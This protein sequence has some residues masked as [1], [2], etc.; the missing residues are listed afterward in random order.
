MVA[1]S[2]GRLHFLIFCYVTVPKP[3]PVHLANKAL[4]HALLKILAL[5]NHQIARSKAFLLADAILGVR[6]NYPFQRPAL[7]LVQTAKSHVSAYTAPQQSADLS[8]T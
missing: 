2:V 5:G 1:K 4:T 7:T 6:S 8:G 3:N